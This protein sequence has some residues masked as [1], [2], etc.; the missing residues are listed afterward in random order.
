MAVDPDFAA[1]R[2][3]LLR[4]ARLHLRDQSAAEDAVHDALLA[5]LQSSDGFLGDSSVRTWLIG[6]LRRKLIDRLRKAQREISHTDAG[7]DADA[8]DESGLISRLFRQNG[9]WTAE[10][11]AWRD[12]DAALEQDEF[13]A[14]FEICVQG[15]PQRCA[16]AF[17][18]REIDG[19]EPAD[20]CKELGLTSSN[21]WVLMHRARLRLRECLENRWF[22]RS[23]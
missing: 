17:V 7:L 15:L 2:D 18:L 6:I 22:A 16:Q 3:A 1:H 14:A 19:M 23:R 12:P 13:Y 4:Y 21:Y 10:P 11:A 20:I 5:A 8:A 9:S